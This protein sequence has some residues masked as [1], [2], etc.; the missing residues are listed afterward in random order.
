MK[1]YRERL[2]E[3]AAYDPVLSCCGD[4]CAVCP[5]RLASTDEELR[6]TAEF[7]YEVGWRNRVVTNDEI[8]C[9][10]CGTRQRCAF[11]ILPCMR[12]HDVNVC[13]ECTKYP[14]ERIGD[15]LRSSAIKAEECRAHCEDD[16]EWR[17]LKR[18]FYEKEKNLK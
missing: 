12:E 14:C 3:M 11:M 7:W 8:R 1:W 6:Q 18:A 16:E 10:G 5:R 4:D 17:M 13:K 2:N 15:M 9:V